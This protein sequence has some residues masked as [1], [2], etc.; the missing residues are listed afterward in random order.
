VTFLVGALFAV[1]ALAGLL[2]HMWRE[3]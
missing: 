3:A 1:L 2:V